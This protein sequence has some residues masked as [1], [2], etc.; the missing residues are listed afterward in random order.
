[1]FKVGSKASCSRSMHEASC[2]RLDLSKNLHVPGVGFS[3]KLYVPEVG[4]S[5]KLY[6]HVET[7]ARRFMFQGI[8]LSNKLHIQG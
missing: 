4:L 1:M 7:R 5:K 3:K 6:A 8:G 2:S